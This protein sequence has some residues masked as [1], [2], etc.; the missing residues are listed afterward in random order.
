PSGFVERVVG[1][2]ARRDEVA[3]QSPVLERCRTG[4]CLHRITSYGERAIIA[5]ALHTTQTPVVGVLL[6][7]ELKIAATTE[8]RACVLHPVARMRQH[9]GYEFLKAGRSEPRMHVGNARFAE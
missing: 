1:E 5:L 2:G 6:G 9:A 3:W 4:Q 8:D 7:Q